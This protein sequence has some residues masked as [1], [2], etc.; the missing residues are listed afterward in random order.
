MI[1]SKNSKKTPHDWPRNYKTK[2]TKMY[3][4]T[5]SG[6]IRHHHK[7]DER[8]NGTIKTRRS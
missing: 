6:R 1:K 7:P 4:Y 8:E 3:I 5:D 2:N